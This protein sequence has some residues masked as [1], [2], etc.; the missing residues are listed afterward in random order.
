MGASDLCFVVVCA[1]P[2]GQGL[3][4]L[5]HQH[6]L[7]PRHSL[8]SREMLLVLQLT[9]RPA[10]F[11]VL[12]NPTTAFFA[13]STSLCSQNLALLLLF[14]TVTA[15]RKHGQAVEQA[16]FKSWH[17]S[18]ILKSTKLYK[19]R[20]YFWWVWRKLIWLQNLTWVDKSLFCPFFSFIH[21]MWIFMFV[22]KIFMCWFWGVVLDFIGGIM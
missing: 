6:F 9:S 13:S 16:S 20:R 18:V 22:A 8:T 14:Q 10:P 1:L 7:L 15:V 21:L 19:N 17:E 3:S 4:G 12:R 5:S 11:P 2:H